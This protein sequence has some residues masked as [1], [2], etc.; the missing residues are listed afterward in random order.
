M[1]EFYPGYTNRC[2]GRKVGFL[3]SMI[4]LRQEA[5]LLR[6][7]YGQ[8]PTYYQ[9]LASQCRCIVKTP[10]GSALQSIFFYEGKK[11]RGKINVLNKT[12]L[13]DTFNLFFASVGNILEIS[14]LDFH[15]R[16]R[17]LKI[18][19]SLHGP[20]KGVYKSTFHQR[21][22]FPNL[23]TSVLQQVSGADQ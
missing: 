13:C 17:K 8:I 6:I 10:T 3:S 14:I 12:R 20:P 16:R 23:T 11:E 15:V 4:P 9:Q 2:V 7:C 19:K 1:N 18:P 21:P 5:S 22:A